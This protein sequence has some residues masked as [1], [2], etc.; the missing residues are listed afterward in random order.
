MS[1]DDDF[2]LSRS[3]VAILGLGLMGG[4][5]ALALRGR[6]AALYGIDPDSA[7]RDLALRQNI[8]DQVEAEPGRLLQ[9][10]DMLVLAV[11]VKVQLEAL[12]PAQ[13]LQVV[14]VV[15]VPLILYM[16]ALL[17]IILLVAVAVLLTIIQVVQEVLAVAVVVLQQ[18]SLEVQVVLVH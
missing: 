8:V 18:T 6:C 15:L 7:T 14:Q 13:I 16:M 4:S 2:I 9:M 5:L 17:L 11:V 1:V 3:K 10:A 12:L